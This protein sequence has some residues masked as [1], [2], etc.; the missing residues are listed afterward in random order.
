MGSFVITVLVLAVLAGV[1][2][3]SSSSY[4]K[5]YDRLYGNRT[6]Y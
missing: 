5:L 4:G 3:G 2:L 6:G 1:V